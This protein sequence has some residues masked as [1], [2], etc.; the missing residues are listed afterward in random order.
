MNHRG[1]KTEEEHDENVERKL[2][3]QKKNKQTY[4]SGIK[5]NN[6]LFRLKKSV[7]NLSPVNLPFHEILKEGFQSEEK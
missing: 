3:F 5:K 4:P 6:Y 7:E 2:P 1:Q